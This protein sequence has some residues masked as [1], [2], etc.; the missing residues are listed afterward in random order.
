ME[1]VELDPAALMELARYKMPFGRFSGRYLKDV[2]EE[3][4]LWLLRRD[5]LSRHFL[6]RV[7]SMLAIKENGFER[8]LDPLCPPAAGSAVRPTSG[9]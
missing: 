9:Q 6:D 5:G 7:R 1:Q 8:L 3:Y 2:P 4:L